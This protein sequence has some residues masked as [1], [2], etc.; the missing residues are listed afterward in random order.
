M[1][2]LTSSSQWLALRWLGQRPKQATYVCENFQESPTEQGVTLL[3]CLM[4]IVITVLA[5]ALITPPLF[6]ATA[7]RVQTRRAEQALQLAQ[8]QVDRYRTVVSQGQHTIDRLPAVVGNVNSAPVP[9]AKAN[10][11]KSGNS[12]CNSLYNDQQI[13]AN[14]ALPVDVDG[15]CKADFL[16]QTFR[17]A[18]VTPNGTT[19]P[20]NFTIGVRVYSIL[21][22]RNLG[23]NLLTDQASL[24]LTSGQGSQ[25]TRP[26][27]VLFTRVN[28]SDRSF[29]LDCIRNNAC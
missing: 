10:F 17:D 3:E 23:G 15:D 25:Q 7:S 16:M 24:Q 12:A 1:M 9:S 22:E 27:A 29:N 5:I 11:L 4:G 8:G 26:L 6:I 21:A 14:Q 19:K 20:T 13:P 28:W 2:K 18:G